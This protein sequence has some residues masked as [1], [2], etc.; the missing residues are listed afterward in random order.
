LGAATARRF[1]EEGA[2]V[3]ITARNGE[4]LAALAQAL[5]K[6]TAPMFIL[7]PAM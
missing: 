1:A 6:E 7:L 2:K 3:A 4:K 5:T